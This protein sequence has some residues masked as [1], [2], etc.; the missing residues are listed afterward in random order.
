[1]LFEPTKQVTGIVHQDAP[2]RPDLVQRE[3]PVGA[4]GPVLSDGHCA[5]RR[6]KAPQRRQLREELHCGE[7]WGGAVWCFENTKISITQP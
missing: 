2:P 1:M 5:A 7:V 6:H 3:E 4:D